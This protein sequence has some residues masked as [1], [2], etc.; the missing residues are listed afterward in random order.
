MLFALPGCASLFS[1]GSYDV[2]FETSPPGA[3]VTVLDV[4]GSTIASRR[5]PFVLRGVGSGVGYFGGNRLTILCA[6]DGFEPEVLKLDT[7]LDA[8]YFGNILFGGLGFVLVDPWT[9]AMYEFEREE[10]FVDL[11]PSVSF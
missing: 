1:T 7:R 8:W 6:L 4:R 9:G 3:H 5:S 11:R 10:V 2:R